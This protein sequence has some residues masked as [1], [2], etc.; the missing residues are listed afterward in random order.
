[1]GGGPNPGK[2]RARSCGGPKGGGPNGGGPNGGGPKF[3]AFFSLSRHSFLFFI[4]SL[5]GLFRGILVVFEAPG[6][7]NV[8]VWSSRAV[9]CEPRRPGLVGPPGF[10]TTTREP[11]RAHLRVPVFKNTTKIQRKR[12]TREGEKNQNCGGR[13]KK[14]SEILGGPAEEGPAEG[15][16]AEGGPAEGGP[17]EGGPAGGPA[18]RP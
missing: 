5:V 18:E 11:K 4:P 8:H 10:H 15:G 7:S 2:V 13:G 1:M 3:R 17:A 16:P 12:P 14:K 6:R 9:V